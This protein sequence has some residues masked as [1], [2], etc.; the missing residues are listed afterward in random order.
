VSHEIDAPHRAKLD[1]AV[2]RP[3]SPTALAATEMTQLS[4]AF[5]QDAP[6]VPIP[7]GMRAVSVASKGVQP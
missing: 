2:L 5:L 4:P 1:F 7:I 3:A 6:S